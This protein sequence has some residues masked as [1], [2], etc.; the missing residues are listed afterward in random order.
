MT[1]NGGQDYGE[2]M[3]LCATGAGNARARAATSAHNRAQ[4]SAAA[5]ERERAQAQ[6]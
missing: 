4:P 5:H 3:N 2:T 1:V 6:L